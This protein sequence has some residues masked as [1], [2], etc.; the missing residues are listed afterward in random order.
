M[1]RLKIFLC[2]VMALSFGAGLVLAQDPVEIESAN[3]E[4]KDLDVQWALGEVV[5]VDLGNNV[6]NARYLDPE[7]NQMKDISLNVD[8][9][10]TYEGVKS[11]EEIKV[12]DSLSIDYL[13]TQD[14]K[15]W[16]KNLGLDKPNE[17]QVAGSVQVEKQANGAEQAGA[18]EKQELEIVQ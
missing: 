3:Q 9:G 18:A 7:D 13:T 15:N 1:K 10:T 5:N 16:A 12:M 17:S 2:G 8:S 11:L 4:L 14:G 6:I